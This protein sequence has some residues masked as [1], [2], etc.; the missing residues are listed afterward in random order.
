M[1]I[2]FKAKLEDKVYFIH[3]TV[4]LQGTVQS[5]HL[6]NLGEYNEIIRRKALK[7]LKSIKKTE[8]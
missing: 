7:L 2:K 5:I 8:Y 3:N 1:K 6:Y 4:I